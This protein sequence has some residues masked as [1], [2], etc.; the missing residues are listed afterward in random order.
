MGELSAP[1][2]LLLLLVL[3]ALTPTV[4]VAAQNPIPVVCHLQIIGINY[5]QSALPSQ[6]IN[7]TSHLLLTCISTVDNVI[8]RVD[9]DQA[10]TNGTLSTNT[11]FIGPIQ[12]TSA[13]YTKVYDVAISN[14]LTAPST[15]GIWKLEVRAWVFA[16]VYVEDSAKKLIQIQ[17]GT[18]TETTITNATTLSSGLIQTQ[19]STSNN[20]GSAFATNIQVV[21]VLVALL[22]IA[23]V[24]IFTRQKKRSPNPTM[25]IN[26]PVP[27]KPL[28]PVTQVGESKLA[29]PAQTILPTG[30]AELDFLLSGGLPVGYAIII[31]SPPCD[32]GDLIFG[33]IIGSALSSGYSVLFLSSHLGRCQYLATRYTRGFYVLSSQADK[34]TPPSPN[35]LKIAGVE[36]LGDLNSSFDKA[37]RSIQTLNQPKLLILDLVSDILL[38][39]RA[40]ASR[41]WLSDFL[42]TRQ[43]EGFTVLAGL[44]PLVSPSQENQTVIDLFDGVI[45]IYEKLLHDVSRRFLIIKKMYGRKYIDTELMLD[46]KKLF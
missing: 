29:V 3:L 2:L 33:K 24:A 45:E 31:V 36:D 35:A 27:I 8:A 37:M 1:R 17:V 14:S 32:E 43:A 41:K 40:L 23:S 46:K 25:S 28:E 9:V 5:A 39:H 42:A 10:N 12:L 19:S 34:I 44:N 26:P 16:D 15:V 18:P 30:Y 11:Y 7:V 6:R 13:P 38:E 21:L 22:L 20:S 4:Q